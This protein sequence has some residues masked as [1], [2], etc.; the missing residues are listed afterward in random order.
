MVTDTKHAERIEEVEML[1]ELWCQDSLDEGYHK[2]KKRSQSRDTWREGID[3]K[4]EEQKTIE[5]RKET[6]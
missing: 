1:R 2:R 4:I 6:A 3:R 5:R